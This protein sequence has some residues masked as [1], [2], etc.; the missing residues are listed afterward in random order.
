MPAKGI[1]NNVVKL[2]RTSSGTAPVTPATIFGSAL[3]LWVRADL[4]ATVVAGTLTALADQSGSGDPLKDMVFIPSPDG[5][6]SYFASSATLNG[7]ACY[8]AVNAP[9]MGVAMVCGPWAAPVPQ[10]FWCFRAW[11]VFGG[12][13][14]ITF[15]GL[16]AG[17]S[18]ANSA[19]LIHN[20][21][22]AGAG[23]MTS[24]SN[25]I[26]F[27]AALDTAH[28]AGCLYDGVTSE[29]WLDAVTTATATGNADTD[30]VQSMLSGQYPGQPGLYL[31]AEQFIV[32][33]PITAGQRTAA[34]QY[35]GT[36]YGVP[37]A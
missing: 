33:G 16:D 31:F 1:C 24:D 13:A 3:A 2:H 19:G 34:M 30:A 25:S 4:G 35:L 18:L 28:V 17:G 8:G 26:M 27:N 21:D 36:R 6:P 14:S 20:T 5:A 7:Q 23:S 12:S 32:S 29:L 15:V 11:I 9:G 10:P 37:L 22:G